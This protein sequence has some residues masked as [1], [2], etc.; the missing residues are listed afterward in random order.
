MR[1]ARLLVG[2]GASFLLGGFRHVSR[3]FSPRET[4]RKTLGVRR[5]LSCCHGDGGYEN[6]RFGGKVARQLA[7]DYGNAYSPDIDNDDVNEPSRI[8]LHDSEW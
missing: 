8:D 3:V 4:T 6:P 1:I 5:A 2:A 7:I